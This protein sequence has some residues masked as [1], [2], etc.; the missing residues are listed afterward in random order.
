M[1]GGRRRSTGFTEGGRRGQGP[2]VSEG[3]EGKAMWASW[4]VGRHWGEGRWAATGPKTEDGPKF[5][6]KFFLISI[7][8]FRIWQNFG[9]LY[10][11]I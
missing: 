11:E 3:E 6:K 8:F 1:R 2:H 10:K 5:K 9:K 4:Q 7:D